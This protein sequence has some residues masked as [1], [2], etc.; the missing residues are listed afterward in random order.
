MAP[1]CEQLEPQAEESG[2]RERGSSLVAILSV[3]A[4]LGI[5]I[6][7]TLS[8]SL[9]TSTPPTHAPSE[10]VTTTSVPKDTASGATEATLAA[11]KANFDIVNSAV[12]TY[13]ALNGSY[14]PA[15]TAWATSE[16][17][18]GPLLQSWPSGERSYRLEWNGQQLSVIPASG[19]A[20]H[21]SFGEGPDVSGCFALKT[22]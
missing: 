5:L 2:A 16:A 6:A 10:S 17:N 4:I 7:L 8:L 20:S 9:G 15:G 11:C 21:G 19:P 12:E 13:R 1:T 14:P 18:G 22:S 3:V